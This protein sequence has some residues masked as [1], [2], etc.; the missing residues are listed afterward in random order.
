MVHTIVRFYNWLKLFY[1]KVFNK[2]VTSMVGAL[3]SHVV[4]CCFEP[5]LALRFHFSRG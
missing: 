5:M 1:F 2:F 4:C 3:H